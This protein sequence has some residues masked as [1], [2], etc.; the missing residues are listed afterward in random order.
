MYFNQL[1]ILGQNY[2]NKIYYKNYKYILKFQIDNIL[3][4]QLPT[5][6]MY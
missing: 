1:S 3:H 2:F 6:N 5:L 4:G